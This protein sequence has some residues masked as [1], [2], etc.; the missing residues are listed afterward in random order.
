MVSL[1]LLLLPSLDLDGTVLGGY[2]DPLPLRTE[3]CCES[4]ILKKEEKIEPTIWY[5]CIQGLLKWRVQAVDAA[6]S[7]HST[8][9]K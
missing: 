4:V 6:A 1:P 5:E 3:S 2:G 7:T 8:S 9:L